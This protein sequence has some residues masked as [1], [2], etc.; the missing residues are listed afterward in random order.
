MTLDTN[1]ADQQ[2][3]S[4]YEIG[5]VVL[6]VHPIIQPNLKQHA[7]MVES[8]VWTAAANSEAIRISDR[9]SES[10]VAPIGR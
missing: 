10:I 2:N 1:L 8:M 6:D 7:G 4:S 5:I 9:T 3:V